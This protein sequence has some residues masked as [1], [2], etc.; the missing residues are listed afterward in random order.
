MLPAPTGPLPRLLGGRPPTPDEATVIEQERGMLL[1]EREA[2]QIEQ[3]RMHEARNRGDA[4]PA[5]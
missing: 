3:E 2:Q 4:D 1:S 5:P